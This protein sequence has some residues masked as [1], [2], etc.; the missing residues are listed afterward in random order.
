MSEGTTGG[1][2]KSEGVGNKEVVLPIKTVSDELLPTF[3]KNRTTKI[4][5]PNTIIIQFYFKKFAT[6]K[7]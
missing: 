5:I 4:N 1:E 6:V 7:N 3:T 2:T